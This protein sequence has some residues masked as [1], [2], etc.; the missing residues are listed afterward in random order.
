M[1]SLE[2][3]RGVCPGRPPSNDLLFRP[4]IKTSL[5]KFQVFHHREPDWREKYTGPIVL[6]PAPRG[7]NA[8]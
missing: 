1:T 6:P 7:L 5:T 4:W 3:F 8:G 2:K